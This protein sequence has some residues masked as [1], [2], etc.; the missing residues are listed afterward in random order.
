MPK[1]EKNFVSN[2]ANTDTNELSMKKISK[3][4]FAKSCEV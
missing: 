2:L 4:Q 3:L 1:K